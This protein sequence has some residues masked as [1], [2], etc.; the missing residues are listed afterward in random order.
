MNLRFHH[1]VDRIVRQTDGNQAEKDDLYEELMTHLEISS[2]QFIKNGLTEKQ[3][4]RKAVEHFGGADEVGSQIQQAMFPFRKE[5]LL[6]L[7]LTSVFFSFSTYIAQLFLE[8]NAHI[9]WLIISITISSLIFICAVYRAGSFNHR[10]W[11]NM[12]LVIHIFVYA[13]GVM[14][15]ADIEG[16]LSILLALLSWF[17]IFIGIAL[18]YW[19]MINDY[20]ANRKSQY[21]SF[22]RLHILNITTGIILVI[23]TLFALWGLL[24]SSEWSPSMLKIFIPL[25]IWL[26]A[27]ILQISLLAKHKKIAYVIAIIPILI[28]AGTIVLLVILWR[29]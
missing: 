13:Y 24:F 2:Q 14:I 21:K 9:I 22:I 3:A 28:L 4:E 6:V 18:L 5:M 1:F 10:F 29:P 26:I 16:H 11:L 12:F 7:S 15:A 20:Q 25:F 23:T 8:S 19:I 27:Y 17:I